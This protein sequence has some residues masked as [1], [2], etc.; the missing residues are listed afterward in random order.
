VATLLQRVHADRRSAV[1]AV[2]QSPPADWSRE[3][4]LDY[5]AFCRKVVDGLRGTHA[6]LDA[7]FDEAAAAADLAHRDAA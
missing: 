2:A 7:L 5:I 6:T 1:R 3:R 4:R